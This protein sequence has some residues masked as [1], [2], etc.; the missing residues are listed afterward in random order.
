M[1]EIAGELPVELGVDDLGAADQLEAV[2]RR[3][4]GEREQRTRDG[5]LGGEISPHRIQRDARQAS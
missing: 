4:I 5:R 3:K 1:L 2:R